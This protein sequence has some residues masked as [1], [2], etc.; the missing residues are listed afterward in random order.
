[1]SAAAGARGDRGGLSQWGGGAGAPAD[2]PANGKRAAVG[3][4]GASFA[5]R[6]RRGRGPG[7]GGS[8]GLRSGSPPAAPPR[9]RGPDRDGRKKRGPRHARAVSGWDYRSGCASPAAPGRP[10]SSSPAFVPESH[11][12]PPRPGSQS[13]TSSASVEVRGQRRAFTSLMPLP[14]GPQ[15]LCQPQVSDVSKIA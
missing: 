9:L 7:L 15:V 5:R 11:S 2:R 14:P 6:L 10:A 13:P 12:E 1:M 3:A 4:G 8:D